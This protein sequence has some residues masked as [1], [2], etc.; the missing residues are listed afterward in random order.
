MSKG[1][2][3]APGEFLGAAG[4]KIEGS[5]CQRIEWVKFSPDGKRYAALCSAAP[6][7]HY[8]IIDGKKGDS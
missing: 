2:Q 7:V 4:K 8:V 5:D 1:G 3:G 6:M